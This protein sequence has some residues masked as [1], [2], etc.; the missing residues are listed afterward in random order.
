L[1]IIQEKCTLCGLCEEVCPVGA[2]SVGPKNV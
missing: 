2:L 1:K